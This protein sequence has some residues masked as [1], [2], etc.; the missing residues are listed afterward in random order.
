MKCNNLRLF[1]FDL[2]IFKK[3]GA[4]V[5]VPAECF[6]DTGVLGDMPMITC[7]V[8]LNNSVVAF[9][10]LDAFAFVAEGDITYTWNRNRSRHY[11][12]IKQDRVN[13]IKVPDVG[14]TTSQII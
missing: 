10:Y 2:D 11:D 8:E 13:G 5:G 6:P 4:F 3:I 1:A 12:L 14:V 9:A 7:T